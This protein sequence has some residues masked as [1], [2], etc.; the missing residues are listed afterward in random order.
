MKLIN[1]SL[2]GQTLTSSKGVAV[3]DEHGVAEVGEE[4]AK[5]LSTM[6]GYRIASE[7][8]PVVPM[9]PM[10]SVWPVSEPK[11]PVAKAIIEEPKKQVKPA[12]KRGKR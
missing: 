11:L 6:P 1:E 7:P 9:N 4:L 5:H 12:G 2:K 3:F 8:E 10:R